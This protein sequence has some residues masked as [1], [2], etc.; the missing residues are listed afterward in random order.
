MKFDTA[1][2]GAVFGRKYV[3]FMLG[4]PHRNEVKDELL[5]WN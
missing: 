1:H 5:Y 2:K 3:G 4:I